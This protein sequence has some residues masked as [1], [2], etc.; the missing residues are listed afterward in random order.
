MDGRC[1]PSRHC[2]GIAEI[3]HAVRSELVFFARCDVAN[4]QIEIANEDG[5]LFV[6]REHVGAR[7]AATRLAFLRAF[8]V[9][10]PPLAADVEGDLRAVQLDFSERQMSGIVLCAGGGRERGG[11]LGV[12]ECRAARPGGRIDHD[13]LG[14]LGG[15]DS[16]PEA[17][18]FDPVR[19]DGGAQHQGV[20]LYVMNFSA[21]A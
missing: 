7:A 1:G 12:I 20:V 6:G 11:E 2:R 9:A 10:L 14:V 18:V 15:C 13:E 21:C 3:L 19:P 5:A 16:V 8:F 17:I 4:P